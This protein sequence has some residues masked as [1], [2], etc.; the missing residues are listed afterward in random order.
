MSFDLD[1]LNPNSWSKSLSKVIGMFTWIA[2][3]WTLVLRF[4]PLPPA[5]SQ[6][7]TIFYSNQFLIHYRS[8]TLPWFVIGLSG[9][10]GAYSS[11]QPLLN[12]TMV[13]RWHETEVIWAVLKVFRGMHVRS[14]TIKRLAAS[15]A[16][17]AHITPQTA[18]TYN[19]WP[20]NVESPRIF[21]VG[22]RLL[23]ILPLTSS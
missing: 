22:V 19:H 12:P 6:C 3:E 13:T 18:F 15:G 16:H 23:R 5:W 9:R 7:K 20:I 4:I 14:F 10:V 11:N 2:R 17:Y 8:W 21:V 1:S